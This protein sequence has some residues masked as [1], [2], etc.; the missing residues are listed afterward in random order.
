MPLLLLP[1]HSQQQQ[2]QQRAGRQCAAPGVRC[3]RVGVAD[4]EADAARVGRVF[5]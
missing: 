4:S 3:F 5:E 2:Q 1:L